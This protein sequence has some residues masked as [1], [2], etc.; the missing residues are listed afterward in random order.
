ML[1]PFF[2]TSETKK[3]SYDSQQ[4]DRSRSTVPESLEDLSSQ[5]LPK[6]DKGRSA[7]ATVGRK[8]Y[9]VDGFT[10]GKNP[11]ATGGGFTITDDS[12][13]VIE[14]RKV[15]KA[16]FTSNEGELLGLEYACAICAVGD[17][18]VTD[19]RNS[20]AWAKSGRPKARPDLGVLAFRAK[21]FISDKS[22]TVTWV[23]R[24]LNKAG[25]FNETSKHRL[26]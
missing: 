1:L 20:I 3:P 4:G 26:R 11:S 18:I 10:Y 16:G 5:Y 6:R 24:H 19:S 7:A 9:H 17:A 21:Q 25:R 15:L 12:G 14:I 23:P 8:T 13:A 2:N 22:L